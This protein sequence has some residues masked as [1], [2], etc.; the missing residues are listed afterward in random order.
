MS[1]STPRLSLCLITRDEAARLPACLDSVGDLVDDIVVVDTG[2]T[3]ATRDLARARGA[4]V[5]ELAWPGDFSVARNAALAAALGRWILVLDADETLPP[6]SHARIRELVAGPARTAYNLVQKS[7]LADGSH[8]SVHIVRLFPNHPRVRFERPIHEQVNTSLEREGIPI[9]DTDIIFDHSG[10]ADPAAH[11]GKAERNRRLIEATLARE[12]DS[13]PNLYY[14]YASIFFDTKQFDRAA[15]EYEE[16]ARR[17]RGNR[18]R[19]EKAALLKAAQCWF[20]AGKFDAA[21]ALLPARPEPDLHPLAAHLCAELAARDGQAAAASKWQEAVLAAP[22]VTY[23]P[24][25]ALAPLKLK[26]L[27][28][29]ANHWAG[30]GR[31]D[32]GVKLLR[33]AKEI[34]S[35]RQDGASPTLATAYR[36]LTVS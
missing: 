12:P 27:L 2:S 33:L 13:D 3:D 31:Q 7:R 20:L 18:R 36:E 22:D 6:A 35:G 10:Y 25:V 9:V 34:S 15:R 30:Q 5:I 28:F 14:F 23:L 17:S 11:S 29:L 1:I 32:I 26:A 4:R 24:P 8:V 16:C 19:L 21:R